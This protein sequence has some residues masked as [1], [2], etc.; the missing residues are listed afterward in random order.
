MKFVNIPLDEE[1]QCLQALEYP[2]HL[3]HTDLK[4][5]CKKEV[6]NKLARFQNKLCAYCE[7]EL[8]GIFIEHYLPVSTHP[9]K[10]LDWD[11]FLAV[12][13]GRFGIKPEIE[14]CSQSRKNLPIH[15]DPR[16]SDFIQTISFEEERILSKDPHLDNELNNILNLN[17]QPLLEMRS[18]KFKELENTFLDGA[19][20]D[21]LSDIEFNHKLLRYVKS[22]FTEFYSFLIYSLQM[23][24]DKLS[25]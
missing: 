8:K 13:S 22:N 6:Q 20:E 21:N 2:Q 11:N 7:R 15:I 25:S 5:D 14:C 12:C 9:D 1:P 17:C 10:Q 3:F 19:F 23:R 18:R 4:S 24:I 16:N